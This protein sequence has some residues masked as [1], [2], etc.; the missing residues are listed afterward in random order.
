MKYIKFKFLIPSF[1][2][3]Y[4]KEDDHG[5]IFSGSKHI[6]KLMYIVHGLNLFFPL[7]LHN[8]PLFGYIRMCF[9]PRNILIVSEF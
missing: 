1:F 4:V 3:L 2:T 9:L 6:C 5:M 7:K 8:M